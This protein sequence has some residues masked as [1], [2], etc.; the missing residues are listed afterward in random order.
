V[1]LRLSLSPYLSALQKG[2]GN[3]MFTPAFSQERGDKRLI[4]FLS[5]CERKQRG[6]GEEMKNFRSEP[7]GFIDNVE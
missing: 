2:K 6:R 5:R 3:T 4:P 1:S 7:I